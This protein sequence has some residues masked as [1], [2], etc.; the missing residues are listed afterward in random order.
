M[1]MQGADVAPTANQIAAC[2]QARAQ[3]AAVLPRWNTLKTAGLGALNAKRRAAG[4][5]PV[6]F[7]S[8]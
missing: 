5:P 1:S 2:G 6:V 3:L 4:Q 8:P 7:P